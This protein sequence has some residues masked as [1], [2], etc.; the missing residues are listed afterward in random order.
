[1]VMA[2]TSDKCAVL[3]AFLINDRAYFQVGGLGRTTTGRMSLIFPLKDGIKSFGL[4]ASLGPT[5]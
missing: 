3:R 2:T 4:Q 5:R 1:M